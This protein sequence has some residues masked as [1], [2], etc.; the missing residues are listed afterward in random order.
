MMPA[1][2]PLG[3][4]PWR[5]QIVPFSRAPMR[6]FA[7]PNVDVVV[8]MVAAQ[9]AKTETIFNVIN[10]HYRTR[11]KPALYV[12]PTEKLCRT[13][14]R[15]RLDEML[16]SNADL[17]PYVDKRY[18][19]PGSMERWINGARL[20]MAWAGSPVELVSHPVHTVF[21]DERGVMEEVIS[22]SSDPVR[23][24]KARTKNYKG[25]KVG[26][27]ST[28]TD[29]DA[30]PTFAWWRQGTKMRWCWQCPGCGHWYA[31]RT[32]DLRFPSGAEYSTVRDEAYIECP[33]CKHEVHDEHRCAWKDDGTVEWLLEQ[34]YVPHVIDETGTITAAP[35]VEPLNRVRSYWVTG[36]CTPFI[37]IGEIAEEVARAGR[38]GTP[39]DMQSV[40]NQYC[41]ELYAVKGDKPPWK[42][43]LGR[44]APEIPADKIQLV[45]AGV[46]VQQE[47]LYYVVRGWGYLAESWL[48][49]HGQLIGATEYDDVWVSL[50]RVL[51]GPWL[52]R[53]LDKALIDSRYQAAQVYK[54]TRRN[55]AW[56]PSKGRDRGR[57]YDDSTVDETM[58]GRALKSLKLWTFNSDTWKQWL[59]ARIL[60]D[61]HE[62]KTGGWWVP[63]GVSEEYC[64]QVTNEK[65]I[66]LTT[67]RRK[68]VPTGNRRNHYL[69]AEVN[70]T[71]AAYIANV[72]TL[73]K[74]KPKGEEPP[75]VS[76][77]PTGRPYANPLARR[78]L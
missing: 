46:D 70:A 24:A 49:D 47:S 14:S 30:C 56:E 69:D 8:F 39:A 61:P 27:F 28:P 53:A 50:S 36:Y 33:E 17:W 64:K 7:S 5:T 15:D 20:G 18:A 60:A 41:G 32:A 57:P 16:R 54:V 51:E 63:D 23:D 4:V 74:A 72:R 6:D 65:C 1:S 67:G 48:L 58:T 44:V 75:P 12:A 31:P 38:E 76:P 52:G 26:V 62:E 11:P 9:S 77:P 25:G 22:G 45:T 43:V 35:E 10:W 55:M 59:Y 34:K 68:W 42:S 78:G 37:T 3:A 2:G 13:L 66:R 73:R 19:K 29:E 40:V 21:V 71:V